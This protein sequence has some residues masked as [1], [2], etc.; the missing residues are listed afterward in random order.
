[1]ARDIRTLTQGLSHDVLAL[2]GPVLATRQMLFDFIV[3]EWRNVSRRTG[4]DPDDHHIGRYAAS[5]CAVREMTADG[6][7]A[8]DT[9]LRSSK[10]LNN[11]IEQDHCGVNFRLGPMLGLKRFRTEAV[12]IAS[13]ESLRRIHRDSSISAAHASKIEVRPPSGTGAGE[14]LK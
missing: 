14:S 4:V 13:I 9:K 11:L 10:Y 1:L 2:A 3:E 5:H 12:I 7:L 8:V 6:E